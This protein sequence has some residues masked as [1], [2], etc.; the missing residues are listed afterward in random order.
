MECPRCGEEVLELQPT[1][2]Y[3]GS[4]DHLRPRRDPF[5][6]GRFD[7]AEQHADHAAALA[8]APERP[9]LG[10]G[11]ALST[12]VF[13]GVVVGFGLGVSRSLEWTPGVFVWSVLGLV[14]VA[15]PVYEIVMGLWYLVAPTRRFTAVVVE[16]T[17]TTVVSNHQPSSKPSKLQ[18]FSK[19]RKSRKPRSRS[20]LHHVRLERRGGRRR[21]Y[22]CSPELWDR[23]SATQIGVAIVQGPRLVDFITLPVDA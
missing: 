4:S 11:P 9:P 17:T 15:F 19:P 23:I 6:P 20:T 1:C 16:L 21:S 7:R 14:L 22:L 12:L 3:C 2:V 13:A 10:L 8:H 18:S 5:A